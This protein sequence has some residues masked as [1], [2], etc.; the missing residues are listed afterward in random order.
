MTK[1]FL[2]ATV[3]LCTVVLSVYLMQ[4][5]KAMNKKVLFILMPEGYQDLEF[6]TPYKLITD[7]GNGVDVAG[8]RL[9]TAHGK[10]GGSF[11]P[12]LILTDMTD[13]DFAKYDAIVIPGGPGSVEHL[14][15]NQKVRETIKYFYNNKKIVASICYAAVAVA[16]TGI[17]KGKKATAFPSD[18]AKKIFKQ[19]GVEYVDQDCVVDIS[20]HMITAQGPAVAKKF[21]FEII[22]M[23]EG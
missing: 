17:L 16:K 15:E 5:G 19:E 18:E 12:N 22:K 2:I 21:G 7:K 8:L 13:T 9:G 11:E 14:W 4:G 23:L 6:N 10:L 3:V 20:E 1:M